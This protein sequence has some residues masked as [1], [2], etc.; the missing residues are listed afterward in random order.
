MEEIDLE[1]LVD[2]QQ[3]I[4]QQCARVA[5]KTVVASKIREVVIPLYLALVRPNL[6]Y[7]VEF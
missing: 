6:E 5:K 1:V 7:R 4:S 2:A 3:N